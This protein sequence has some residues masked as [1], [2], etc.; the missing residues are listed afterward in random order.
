MEKAYLLPTA[1][2]IFDSSRIGVV[3]CAPTVFTRTGFSR[4]ML[5]F[6]CSIGAIGRGAV[7][8]GIGFE[9]EIHG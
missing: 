4:I 1:V 7:P 9:E 3:T 8:G 6:S 5:F 2:G